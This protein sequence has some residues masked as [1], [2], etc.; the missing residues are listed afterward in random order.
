MSV[1]GLVDEYL[2]FLRIER[3][4][5]PRT[6]EAY[7]RDLRSYVDYL[8]R[9][10]VDD[11]RAVTREA[12]L[13]FEARL[14]RAGY[15]PS[16]INRRMSVVKGFHRYL[17]REEYTKGNPAHLIDTPKI[18]DRLPDVLSVAQVFALLDASNGETP[19]SLRDRALLEVLYGCGLRA[20][21]ACGLN[22]GDVRLEEGFLLVHGKGG[23]ERI[24]P[25]SGAAAQSLARYLDDARATLSLKARN[26]K[27][28]DYAAVFLNARGGRLTRQS[29]YNIVAAAGERVGIEGLHPHTLRHS[30]ATHL[31][32]GGAD[33]RV[34]Q[35]MLGHSSIS[36][37]QIYTH[38]DRTH[39][40]EEYR[41][42]HPRW[43][44]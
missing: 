27:P 41:Q 38:I 37:T 17:E 15:A 14:S 8:A 42:A 23:K 31:L 29:V 39:L 44:A 19:T 26:L 25:V 4:A 30:F 6:V 43:N 18:P 32:E 40:Q 24:A 33:L 9:H 12:V 36:T 13:D 34:I 7:E 2:S 3:G 1:A 35:E 11:V 28:A 5:S 16:S 21:E 10:G 22:L 20:S